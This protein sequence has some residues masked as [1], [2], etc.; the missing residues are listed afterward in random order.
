VSTATPGFAGRG[1]LPRVWHLMGVLLLLLLVGGCGPDRSEPMTST[2]AGLVWP[3]PP[4]QP[5]IMYL[6]E[7]S[8]EEDLE[9]RKPWLQGLGELVFG[10]GEVGI[11]VS[12]YAVAVD[13][14]G[15]MF[16]ADSG[17]AAVH[18]F[19][20]RTRAYNQFSRLSDEATL[21]KPVGLAVFADRVYVVDSILR[22]VCVFK[23]N[24]T[25]LF[26]FGGERFKR[27]SGIACW[28]LD[29]VLYVADTSSHVIHIFDLDGKFIKQLGGRGLGAG[30]FNFPTH[31]WVDQRGQLYVS[32]TLNYRIQVFTREGQF[33]KMFGRQGDRPG[34]FAHP[35]GVATDRLGNI[36]VTDRQFENVQV[37]NSD[38]Q[39]LMAL[40]Q[41]GKEPGEFWLPG[42][43]FVDGRNRIYVA[44]S[45]NKRIQIFALREDAQP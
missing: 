23:K 35:C 11:L 22:Q 20:L 30:Q 5:R 6:G 15:M 44:D 37:F 31:L 27:P 19:N 13:A 26:S 12:P 7:I 29:G 28:G 43:I 16:V 9:K 38:G 36:Y 32:D 24:G 4:E 45:F 41:E 10:E 17:G 21:Q 14:T 18:V 39:I 3:P 40:G 34:N 2:Q 25:F 42:G 33:L 8:T 1:Q